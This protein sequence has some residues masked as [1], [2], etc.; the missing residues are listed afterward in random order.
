MQIETVLHYTCRDRN[1]LGMQ[2]DLI[3]AAGLGP[4]NLLCITGDPPKMGPYPNATAVFDIDSIG[5]VNMVAQHNRGR[6]L[7]GSSIGQSTGFSV[8]VGANPA[9]PDLE[10][11]FAR[12]RYKVEA[13]AADGE[14]RLKKWWCRRPERRGRPQEGR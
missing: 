7:G 14:R 12:F 11:E 1:I 3:G 5:L 9:A 13:G 10:R 4:R 8:G 6:D 2:S